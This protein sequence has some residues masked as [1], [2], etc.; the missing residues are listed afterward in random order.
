MSRFMLHCIGALCATCLFAGA[1]QAAP[2]TFNFT[3][4]GANVN[5]PDR[6]A[7]AKY[8]NPPKANKAT[9][10]S[11]VI[12]GSITFE[13]SLLQNPGL[14]DFNLPNP[15]VLALTATVSG[16]S[17]GNGTF[18]MSDFS[19]V[20]FD[21]NGGTLNFNQQL[22]GQPTS[23]SPWGSPDGNGGDF[24]LFGNS[25]SAPNGEFYFTLCT[26]GGNGDCTNLISA[27]NAI[28]AGTSA[29]PALGRWALLALAGLLGLAGFTGLRR[30][31]KSH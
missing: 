20:V 28:A 30:L 14:N 12:T 3:F 21:T 7:S 16:A 22:V 19:E 6:P 24:N 4:S 23:G 31:R 15:A 26:N 17:S 11:A 9:G 5:P 10:N 8:P 29:T 1:L 18:G 27:V 2:V 25:P 13:D